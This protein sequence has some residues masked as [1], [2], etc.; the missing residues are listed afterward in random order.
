MLIYEYI[1]SIPYKSFCFIQ[2][3]DLSFQKNNLRSLNL[4]AEFVQF[5]T[6]FHNTAIKIILMYEPS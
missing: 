4:K 2:K 3:T 1:S 5:S 6:S